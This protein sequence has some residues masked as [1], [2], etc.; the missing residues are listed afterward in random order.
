MA[1][2][3]WVKIQ[4]CVLMPNDYH[5]QLKSGTPPNSLSDADCPMETLKKQLKAT[6]K[7]LNVR[8]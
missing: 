7:R 5:L 6:T 2:A 3:I 8:Y 1:G 4:A